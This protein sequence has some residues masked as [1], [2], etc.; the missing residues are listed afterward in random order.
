MLDKF[1]GNN[2]PQ[3]LDAVLRQEFVAGNRALAEKIVEK[4]ELVL[5]EKDGE[6]IK[7]GADDNDIYL[8][9]AGSVT[10]VINGV[11]KRVRKAGQHIGEMSAIE[12]ALARSATVVAREKTVALKLTSSD[13][14]EIGRAHGEIWLPIAKEL[15]RRLKDRNDD[16]PIPNTSPRVFIISSAEAILTAE[17]IQHGLQHFHLP[18]IWSQGVFFAGEYPLESLE[19]AVEESDFAIAVVHPDDFVES[20]HVKQRTLRD[21]VVFELG[22]FMGKLKRHRAILVAPKDEAIKLP[23]DWTGLN[24]LKYSNDQSLALAHRLGP[25]CTDIKDI[26]TRYGVRTGS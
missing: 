10:L 4:G 8:L 3:L 16:I 11:E 5:F 18:R 7:Q 23:S 6:V 26:V 2:A 1:R 9:V 22:L 14:H 12:P 25:V 15:A 24:V 20:R 13:L 17:G 21:N 19:A